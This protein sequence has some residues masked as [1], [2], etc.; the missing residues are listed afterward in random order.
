MTKNDTM[1]D[2]LIL[3]K[4]ETGGGKCYCVPHTTDYPAIPLEDERIMY[5]I[6]SGLEQ[7]NADTSLSL[8]EHFITANT[9]AFS[10]ASL[11]AFFAFLLNSTN[12]SSEKERV[13]AILRDQFLLHP[14]CADYMSMTYESLLLKTDE[15]QFQN[16]TLLDFTLSRLQTEEMCFSAK[17]VMRRTR[18]RVSYRYSDG[19]E[20]SSSK[21]QAKQEEEDD[22]ESRDNAANSSLVN[23]IALIVLDML[24]KLLTHNLRATLNRGLPPTE[25]LLAKLIFKGTS[26]TLTFQPVAYNLFGTYRSRSNPDE[27]RYVAR[28]FELASTLCFLIDC[29]QGEA[30]LLCLGSCSERFISDF[31]V[32]VFDET[33]FRESNC[34]DKIVS[35][36]LLWLRYR[37]A[38]HVLQRVLARQRM[39]SGI[40]GVVNELRA[41]LKLPSDETTTRT[42][43]SNVLRPMDTNQCVG[44]NEGM[45]NDKFW[46]LVDSCLKIFKLVRDPSS[47]LTA[48]YRQINSFWLNFTFF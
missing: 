33:D 13:A 10:S 11:K 27:R 42:T 8:I 21:K 43:Q 14:S 26:S 32:H 31:L 17:G 29:Q 37:M 4:L 16:K 20:S 9:T 3:S 28:L 39:S 24:T 23:D 45:L 30:D 1:V 12:S 18:K 41:L 22:S 25:C 34:M 35:S 48:S 40:K 44:A 46:K 15:S 6:A 5:W 47:K 7:Q 19:D 36:N 38:H 2:S